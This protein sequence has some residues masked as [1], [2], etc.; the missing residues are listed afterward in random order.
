MDVHVKHFYD[1][2][3]K[4]KVFLDVSLKDRT[5]KIHKKHLMTFH[6]KVTPQIALRKDN[7]QL[8]IQKTF[9]DKA[10]QKIRAGADYNFYVDIGDKFSLSPNDIIWKILGNFFECKNIF[11]ILW[12]RDERWM[13]LQ[14]LFKVNLKTKQ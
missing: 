12:K 14:L 11:K 5:T 9:S 7:F 8:Q 1:I 3:N 4:W 13:W 6:L 2:W 10:T